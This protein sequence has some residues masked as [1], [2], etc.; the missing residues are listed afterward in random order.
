MSP[1]P[2]AAPAAVAPATLPAHDEA[3]TQKWLETEIERAKREEPPPPPP[4]E[5]TAER[6]Y[7]ASSAEWHATANDPYDDGRYG[8]RGAYRYHSYDR[9]I[10][11]GTFPANTILGAG[12]GAIVGNQHGHRGRGAWIGGSI[13]FLLDQCARW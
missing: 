3:A 9:R 8:Y 11:V 1:V 7:Y 10:G 6:A 2:I 13:G 5:A 4:P 12:I